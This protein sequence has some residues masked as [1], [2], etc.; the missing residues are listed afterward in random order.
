MRKFAAAVL[1]LSLPMAARGQTCI[2]C[3]INSA[4][5]QAAQFNVTS[6]TVR[7]QLTVGNLVLSTVTASTV[8]ASTAFIGPGSLITNLNATQLKTGTISTTVVSGQYFGITGTGALSTGTWTATPVGTQYGGTGKNWVAQSTGS[9]P[10]FSGNGQMSTLS[11]GTPQALLQTNGAAAPVWTSSP[12]VSGL[13]L[14]GIPPTALKAGNLPTNI[15]VS[16]NSIPYVNGASVFGNIN[17]SVSSFTGTIQLTQLATGTLPSSVVASSITSTNVHAGVYGDSSHTLQLTMR[18]DGRIS[19]MTVMNLSVPLSGLQSGILPGGVTV[20][21]ASINS[22][23]LGGQVVASSVAATGATAGTY[24]SATQSVQISV[25]GDGRISSISQF[26]I[27]GASTGTAFS[28]IDNNWS[29]AQTSQS[30]WTFKNNVAVTGTLSDTGAGGISST[31][32]ITAG[33][34]TVPTGGHY[35]LDN[36]H[37]KGLLTGSGISGIG[38]CSGTACATLDW[39]ITAGT[40]YQISQP[41]MN[42]LNGGN[43]GFTWKNGGASTQLMALDG[44]GQWTVGVPP[45]ISTISAGN[46][47]VPYGV[48]AS[49]FNGNGA[50]LTH[51]TAANIDAGTLGPSVIAS[52]IAVGA[53]GSAQIASSAVDTTKLAADAV[54]NVKIISAAVDTRAIAADS[55]ITAKLITGAVDTRVIAADAVTN[56]KI[57]T[58]AVDTNKLS[59]D[60]VTTVKLITGAVDTRALAGAAVKTASIVDNAINTNKLAG[61]AVTTAS[62]VDSAVNTAKIATD[63][64]TNAKIISSAVDTRAIASDAVTSAALLNSVT[65]LAKVTGGNATMTSSALSIFGSTSTT[66]S[67]GMQ[68][69]PS[70]PY[71][72][73]Q[74]TTSQNLKL[75]SVTPIFFGTDT[76]LTNIGHDVTNSSGTFTISS[77]MGGR[78]SMSGCVQINN[79]TADARVVAAITVGGSSKLSQEYSLATGD[80]RGLCV[81]GTIVVSAGDQIQFTIFPVNTAQT[82]T[83]AAGQSNFFT[84]YKVP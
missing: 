54:T 48:T 29:H 56:A 34:V 66:N 14:Y 30:S 40:L 13:N 18:T 62:I 83:N 73:S 84:I 3:I 16:S 51:L 28:N 19:T 58:G 55:V 60:A 67:S 42:F 11:G 61:G 37:D 17:G 22:G 49:T 52:S 35:F 71:V 75:S 7:G 36:A 79:A 47:S 81:S 70:Q 72:W 74:R 15:I 43:S 10:Y 31:Y 78:Y 23:T 26:A 21:A 44:N 46:L 24:G 82:T 9:I 59:A 45:T 65:S 4:A 69:I 1:M 53:V 20:P 12:A 50:S 41:I 63:A 64:V 77:G 80:N 68:N 27:P 8:T 33:S 5:P 38:L 39:D 32:G 76:G 25:G 57:I 6:G 2:N